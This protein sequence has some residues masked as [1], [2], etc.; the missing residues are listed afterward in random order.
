MIYTHHEAVWGAILPR[1]FL[2]EDL[3]RVL[4]IVRLANK[5]RRNETINLVAS[6]NVMSRLAEALYLCDFVGRY[7]GESE[8]HIAGADPIRE[9]MRMLEEVFGEML[10]AKHVESR[11]LSGTMANTAVLLGLVKHGDT[12][13][14]LPTENGGHPS[15][16]PEGML[17]ALGVKHEPLPFDAEELNIDVDA[18][19][20]LMNEKKPRLIVLGASAYLF[21]HPVREIAEHAA[22][23][24]ARVVYDASH[25]LGLI[26]GGVWRNPLE[27]GASIMTSSTHK[28]F[29][30]PQG[31]IVLFMDSSDYE[32][33]SRIVYP[34]LVSNI[35]PHRIPAT[36]VT[37]IEMR[38]F[39]NRY[40][41]QVVS[42]A[43]ALAETLVELGFKVLG[44]EKG[45]TSSHQVLVDVEELGGG[46]K[47]ARM[48]EEANIMVDSFT[49]PG[50][51]GVKGLRLG[52]QEMT[53]VG[54]REPEMMEIAMLMRKVLIERRD[55]GE[56]KKQVVELRSMFTRVKY[57]FSL[58]EEYAE[59]CTLFLGVRR[60]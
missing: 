24:G 59:A 30:G 3:T 9:L 8:E 23:L 53:R 36:L 26:M 7:G 46:D 38:V 5:R 58:P 40:A 47:C 13:M 27:D 4:E 56:V 2:P 28:T 22:S 18:T 60:E 35:H 1:V 39:G 49:L 44:E 21:P 33:V 48:L 52:T 34:R 14:S 10:G 50:K 55:P 45:F 20:R 31:G 25:V 16:S 54:M 57:G 41:S 17:E 12:I 29:P 42:N 37:A 15:F 43:R 6:E 11:C 32:S 19:I 51:K